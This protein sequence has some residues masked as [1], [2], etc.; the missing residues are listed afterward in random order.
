MN[1][2]YTA[3][4]LNNPD[5]KITNATVQNDNSILIDTTDGFFIVTEQEML[6]FLYNRINK[7]NKTQLKEE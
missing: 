1:D 5:P 4:K 7:H 2:S 3:D 6:D